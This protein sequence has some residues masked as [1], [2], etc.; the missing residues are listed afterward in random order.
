MRNLTSTIS[1]FAIG[2]SLAFVAPSHLPTAENDYAIWAQAEAAFIRRGKLKQRPNRLA[3]IVVTTAATPDFST[4]PGNVTVSFTGTDGDGNPFETPEFDMGGPVAID[5]TYV[6]DFPSGFNTLAFRVGDSITI[7]SEEK[8]ETEDFDETSFLLNGGTLNYNDAETDISLRVKQKRNGKLSLK[9]S[10][11][12]GAMEEFNAEN[13]PIVAISDAG[14]EELDYAEFRITGQE[15]VI[16]ADIPELNEAAAILMISRVFDADGN[17]L[18]ENIEDIEIVQPKV[19]PDLTE[20]GLRKNRLKQKGGKTTSTG[21]TDLDVAKNRRVTFAVKSPIDN[22]D[23]VESVEYQLSYNDG[24]GNQIDEAPVTLGDPDRVRVVEKLPLVRNDD[25]TLTF[26]NGEGTTTFPAEGPVPVTWIS[27]VYGEVQTELEILPQAKDREDGQMG[28]KICDGA[29][30]V[31]KPRG[32]K[33]VRLALVDHKGDGSSLKVVLSGRPIAFGDTPFTTA[34]YGEILISA[35][36][37]EYDEDRIWVQP[38]PIEIPA[39]LDGQSYQL[40]ATAFNGNGEVV[41]IDSTAGIIGAEEITTFGPEFGRSFLS[42]SASGNLLF[43]TS[44]VNSDPSGAFGVGDFEFTGAFAPSLSVSVSDDAMGVSLI[45]IQDLAPS[46]RE[47]YGFWTDM[48]AIEPDNVVDMEYLVTF[49]IYAP[50]S[51]SPEEFN[52]VVVPDELGGAGELT[53][54]S[55]F[56]DNVMLM[57]VN[58][59]LN[60]DG[61]TFSM[62]AQASREDGISTGFFGSAEEASQFASDNSSPGYAFLISRIAPDDGGSEFDPEKPD[63]ISEKGEAL[64]YSVEGDAGIGSFGQEGGGSGLVSMIAKDENEPINF[65]TIA[66]EDVAISSKTL[67]FKPKKKF[68]NKVKDQISVES[69]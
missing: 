7:D 38:P 26:Q 32:C 59:G 27:P 62:L 16:E 48:T 34:L 22:T 31:D 12:A 57:G 55:V 29:V 46:S 63:V 69:E 58:I 40:T 56:E 49:D 44:L 50:G 3:Q 42:E 25:Q 65:F 1:V 39:A 53:V 67:A 9:F 15:R 41:D 64:F 51:E 2:A 36:P 60:E 33:P 17:L 61:E 8:A 43:E 6:V 5:A 35:Q 68:V 52:L 4:D 47:G 10:G 11:A 19:K 20:Y 37:I 45:D 23:I 21:T 30:V 14:G 18:D 28:V 24:L 54:A 13:P 66:L